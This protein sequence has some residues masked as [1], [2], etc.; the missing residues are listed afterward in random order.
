MKLKGTSDPHNPSNAAKRC[1][2]LGHDLRTTQPKVEA[3]SKMTPERQA[4]IMRAIR[5]EGRA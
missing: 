2:R 4:K 5:G 3:L 1:K